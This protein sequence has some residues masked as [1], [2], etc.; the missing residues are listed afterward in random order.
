MEMSAAEANAPRDHGRHKNLLWCLETDGDKKKMAFDL[1]S[2]AGWLQMRPELR[3][4]PKLEPDWWS[5]LVQKKK[6]KKSMLQYV[7]A[8]V[9]HQ[10]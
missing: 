1:N 6:K 3:I 8:G 10:G 5:Q 7:S 9:K 2:F 4:G